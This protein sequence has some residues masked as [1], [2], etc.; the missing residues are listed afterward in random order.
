MANGEVDHDSCEA[1]V[2]T[3]GANH[4]IICK[5]K[6]KCTRVVSHRYIISEV[7]NI[8]KYWSLIYTLNQLI[9]E[10]CRKSE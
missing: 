3:E 8:W 6:W 1:T 7:K 9:M 4:D 5:D 2:S 10:K